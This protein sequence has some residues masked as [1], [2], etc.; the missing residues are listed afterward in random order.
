MPIITAALAWFL[1]SALLKATI[2]TILFAIVAS[3]VPKIIT[4][5]SPF[6]GTAGL[7]NA[8]ANIPPGIWF[9]IDAMRL[10]FGL[11]LVIAAYIARFLIRRIPVIG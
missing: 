6:I 10:D 3:L 2:L 11:P 1:R 4:Y 5:I 9:F 8:F 7:N